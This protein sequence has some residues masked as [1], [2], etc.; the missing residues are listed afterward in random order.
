MV[1]SKQDF[2]IAKGVLTK[3]NGPGGDVVIPAGVKKIG[4][5]AFK[6][7]AALTGVTIP[8]GVTSIG[9]R[10]FYG[11]TELQSAVIPEGVKEISG[12]LFRGCAKL[13]SVTIPESVR[14]IG[15]YAFCDCG[16][17]P[18][19]ALPRSVKKI[20]N[21]AFRGCHWRMA[22]IAPYFPISDFERDDKLKAC[23][24][25]ARAYLENAAPDEEINA[26]YLRYIKSQRKNLYIDAIGDGALLH[27]LFAA[28]LIQ[29]KDIEDLMWYKAYFHKDTEALIQEYRDRYLG[30]A[31]PVKEAEQ[32]RRPRR[33]PR[34]AWRNLRP[35][36]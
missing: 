32:K 36:A 33:S 30:P 24:G 9:E 35:P 29:P 20:G 8:D 6:G 2:V 7:C 5:G 1:E 31:D 19:V 17:L 21:Y 27:L 28:K 12:F 10:A 26:G 13:R 14:A 34:R 15:K 3:Y 16:S 4:D 11:C 18:S 25:F 22:L 23:C